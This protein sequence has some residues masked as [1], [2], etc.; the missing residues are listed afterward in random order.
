MVLQTSDSRSSVYLGRMNRSSYSVD[1]VSDAVQD[2]IVM[3]A[4][5]EINV[6]WDAVNFRE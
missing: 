4:E 6:I 3:C 1:D 5:S 2:D